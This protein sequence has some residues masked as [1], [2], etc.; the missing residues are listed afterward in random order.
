MLTKLSEL[1]QYSLF[2][3]GKD[4]CRDWELKSLE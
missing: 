2:D 3:G 4:V 1:A